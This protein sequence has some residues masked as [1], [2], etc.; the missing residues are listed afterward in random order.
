MKLAIKLV[1]DCVLLSDAD[2]IEV[3]LYTNEANE[4]LLCLS[5]GKV[6]PL[7][8]GFYYVVFST[9]RWK[10]GTLYCKYRTVKDGVASIW[11]KRHIGF[12]Q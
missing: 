12:I 5:D 6:K 11:Y 3:V 4:L 8:E 2:D 9:S 10:N 7:K 1:G